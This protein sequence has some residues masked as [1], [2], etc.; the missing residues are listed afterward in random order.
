MGRARAVNGRPLRESVLAVAPAGDSAL[1]RAARGCRVVKTQTKENYMTDISSIPLNKLVDSA[2]W[3]RPRAP[4]RPCRNWQHR[5]QRTGFYS[6][7]SCARPRRASSLSW[8]AGG[9]AAVRLL[10][11]AG[12]IEADYAVPCQVLDSGIDAA[13]ISLAENSVREPMHPADEATRSGALS[14]AARARRMSQRG[15]ASRKPSSAA[16]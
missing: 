10:A 16:A 15:L 5:L 13:E 4:I 12:K 1:D 7:A 14:T 6:R 8:R 3:A 2:T 9:V 11:E